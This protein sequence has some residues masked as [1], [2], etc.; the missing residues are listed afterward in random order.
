[1]KRRRTYL[2]QLP[3]F[4]PVELLVVIISS[5]LAGSG[6]WFQFGAIPVSLRN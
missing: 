6:K 5:E 3:A 1:M 2:G 4:T